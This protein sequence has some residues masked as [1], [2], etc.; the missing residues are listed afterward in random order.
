MQSLGHLEFALK[1]PQWASLREGDSP[2]DACPSQPGTARL[3]TA[4]IDQIMSVAPTKLIHIG[5]DEVFTLGTCKVCRGRNTAPLQ[6]YVEHV[7][8]IA[9]HVKSQWGARVLIWDDMLRHAPT[10]LLHTLAGL[11]EPTVWA[12]GPDVTRMVPPYI[13]RTYAAVFPNVWVAPAFKGATG[14]RALMPDAARHAANTLAWIE[15][16]RRMKSYS[17]LSVAGIIITGWSRYDHFAVLC[18]LLPPS[19]P[20]LVL[21]LL[22]ASRGYLTP[23]TLHDVHAL[24]DCPSHVVIDP[25]RDPHLWA[26]RN[27]AFPGAN[28]ASL[29]HSYI[30]LRDDIRRMMKEAEET[31]G[32]LTKYNID[33]N[34]SPPKRIREATVDLRRLTFGLSDLREEALGVLSQYHDTA[35]VSEWIEQHLVP[36]N[37]TLTNL[38]Q[39]TERLLSVSTWP[40]RPLDWL[41]SGGA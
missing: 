18:E 13:L 17:G 19:T 29:L 39:T 14:P 5:A 22:T 16:G 35:T 7:S 24:L 11:V 23:A 9:R 27:C 20:S 32:W 21:S 6:L 10:T 8:K 33:H 31:G 26:S 15:V 1:L 2:A 12:Y 38:A 3:V 34:F 40:R 28:V 36:L 37:L 25:A 4:A 41:P 30:S